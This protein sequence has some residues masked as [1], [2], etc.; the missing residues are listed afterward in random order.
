MNKKIKKKPTRKKTRCDKKKKTSLLIFMGAIYIIAFLIVTTPFVLIYGPYDKIKKTFITTVLATRHAYL[1]NDFIPQQTLDKILGKNEL[2]ED[3]V[4]ANTSIDLNKI[5]VKNNS[6]NKVTKYDIHTDRYDGYMLEIENPHKV[7]VAMTKYL[8]KLGQ[9]TSEMAEEHNAI[10]AINGGSFVDKSSDGITYAGTGG[11]PGGFVISSGKVVYPIGKCNEHSVEN[12]IA[13]TKKG[14][15]IVGNH[16]LAELKKLDV[17]EAMCFREPNVIINGI[18]QHK[19]EDYIDG[20]NPRTAVGQ[21]EDGTVLFLALDGRKLS[22]PGATIYEVQEIM[23]SRG[24]INAGMLDGGYSTTMYYKGDVINS[25]NA[26]DGER[27][28]ATAFYVEQ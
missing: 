12:V 8:G 9:K 2:E 11:Q 21:K 1:V 24:A 27:S 26:W 14:Q 13:F 4:P 25:P 22:K 23:R 15:L 10:A 5:D 17:Q 20:I 6:G 19:K 3:S 18:R 28:V 7:K 16:T